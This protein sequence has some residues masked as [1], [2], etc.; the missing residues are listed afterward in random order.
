MGLLYFFETT[1]EF[2]D[3][4]PHHLFKRWLDIAEAFN[5]YPTTTTGVEIKQFWKICGEN[6]ML[7]VL[8]VDSP[9]DLDICFATLLKQQSAHVQIT[10]EVTPFRPYEDF[11]GTCAERSRK[12]LDTTP[13]ESVTKEGL[14]YFIWSRVEYSGISQQDLLSTWT[15]EA[16][17]ALEAKKLGSIVDLWKVVAERQVW[18]IVC[19]NNPGDA[20]ELLTFDL[21]ILKEMGAQVYSKCKS[22]RPISCWIEDLKKK[23]SDS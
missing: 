7:G 3:M 4:N 21:P 15:E 20:D 22:I 12:T 18:V 8:S 6:K 13:I 14:Y 5:E 9:G 1:I 2:R 19:F 10:T 17:S 23:L 16:R 11:A